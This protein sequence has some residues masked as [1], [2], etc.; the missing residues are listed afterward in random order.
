MTV[1]D[2]QQRR[3]ETQI[4]QQRQTIVSLLSNAAMASTRWWVRE[5]YCA[6]TYDLDSGHYNVITNIKAAMAKKY[7]CDACDTLY[8]NKYKGDKTFPLCTASPPCTKDQT[9]YRSTCNMWFLGEK[10][11]QNHLTLNVKGKLVCQYKKLCWN[12][13]FTVTAD[14][15]L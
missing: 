13:S 1:I 7:I 3:C 9:K 15:K 10:C 4:C 5:I 6:N 12:C 8:D 2:Q 11:F 14:S